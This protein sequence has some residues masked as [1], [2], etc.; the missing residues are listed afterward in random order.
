M[1]PDERQRAALRAVL[2]AG[3]LIVDCALVGEA[4]LDPFGG[5]LESLSIAGGLLLLLVAL[6]MLRSPRSRQDLSTRY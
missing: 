6:E 3:L 2:A 5:S 1:S 4:V